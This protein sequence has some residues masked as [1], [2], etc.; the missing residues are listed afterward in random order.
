M[1]IILPLALSFV[2]LGYAAYLNFELLMIDID[3]FY[4]LLEHDTLKQWKPFI[5]IPQI[6]SHNEGRTVFFQWHKL[7]YKN[8]QK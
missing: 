7:L 4:R 6:I 3:L 8:R 5:K 1:S 2:L